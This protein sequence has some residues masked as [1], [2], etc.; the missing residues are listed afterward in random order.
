MDAGFHKVRVYADLESSSP[1]A[2][3]T[4]PNWYSA[5]ADFLTY[6]AEKPHAPLADDKKEQVCEPLNE[7]EP[8]AH[9]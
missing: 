5:D 1:K 4:D 9:S 6:V 2:V 7:E 8:G 3:A